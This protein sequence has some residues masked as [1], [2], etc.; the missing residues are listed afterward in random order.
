MER[1]KFEQCMIDYFEGGLSPEDEREFLDQIEASEESRQEFQAF[2]RQEG[3]LR[4]FFKVHA[5]RAARAEA[6]RVMPAAAHSVVHPSRRTRQTIVLAAAAALLVIVGAGARLVYRRVI[7]AGHAV[8]A[9]VKEAE[10]GVL[11]LSRGSYERVSEGAPLRQ[12][13]KIKVSSGGYLAARFKD[14][15]LLE[16]RGGSQVTLADFPNRFEAQMN[17]GQVWVHLKNKPTKRFIVTTAHLTATATGTVFG[18]EEGLD[19][20]MVSVAEGTVVVNSGGTQ[21]EVSAGETFVSRDA[22]E[23][24]PSIAWSHYPEN[25]TALAAKDV[26]S[27][28]AGETTPLIVETASIPRE[29]RSALTSAGETPGVDDLLEL[30]PADTRYF[31]DFR[32][33]RAVV[34][35]FERSDYSRMVKDPSVRAWWQGVHGEEALDE[36]IAELHLLEVFDLAKLVDGQLVIGVT[37]QGQF[38]LVADCNAHEAQMRE[39]LDRIINAAAADANPQS[40]EVRFF[41]S[42]GRRLSEEDWME[43]RRRVFVRNGRLVISSA[44]ELSQGTVGRLEGGPGS[45]FKDSDFYRKV[46]R[47]AMNGRFVAAVDLASLV[48]GDDGNKLSDREVAWNQFAGIKGLDYLILSPDFEGRGMNQAARLGFKGEREG[49]SD[50]LA[51]PRPMRSTD[52]FSPEVHFFAVAATRTPKQ[53]YYDYLVLLGRSGPEQQLVDAHAFFDKHQQLFEAFGG[54]AAIALESPIL[55]VPNVK[56]VFEL[57]NPAGFESLLD[58]YLTDLAGELH[59]NH[60]SV[61]REQ[62][63]YQG[64]TIRTLIVEGMPV[65]PSYAII[66]DYLVLGPGAEFVRHSI[67]VYESGRSISHDA[68]LTNLLPATARTNFSAIMYQDVA[69]S[70]P[71]MMKYMTHEQ[72]VSGSGLPDLRF[73]DGYSAPGVIYAYAEPSH[74]DFYLNANGGVDMNLGMAAPLVAKWLVPRTQIGQ[75]LQSCDE[76][77]EGLEAVKLAAQ[78]FAEAKGRL[79]ATMAELAQDGQYLKT[80][81]HDPFASAPGSELR[82]VPNAESGDIVIYSVGPDGVDDQGR[83]PYDPDSGVDGK[84]DI[85]LNLP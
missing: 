52:F 72:G 32:D 36:A 81:P 58:Q 19:R 85:V 4:G 61:E 63:G 1:D 48:Q 21:T 65:E 73:L 50:W 45:G 27:V 75:L 74:L 71:D 8:L 53:M 64:R 66:E 34:D 6:P 56:L 40:S 13:E 3:E 25:L 37:P 23:A 62:A 33:W 84:G 10:G 9:E 47:D 83:I 29:A 54:E 5:E 2:Q 55:P 46:T 31:V 26:A 49:I 78:A 15:N 20:S 24:S 69:R 7:P 67:D 12:A 14:G 80:V 82:L 44:P 76:A 17:R 41:G 42:S 70:L 35:A 22:A 57:K 38:L 16:A 30:L 43:I 39:A 79:P 68:R 28:P 18:V 60:R 59:A 77:R 11:T 51:E